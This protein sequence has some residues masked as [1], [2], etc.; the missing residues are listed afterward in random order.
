MTYS[1]VR[2]HRND[3]LMQTVKIYLLALDVHQLVVVGYVLLDAPLPVR[4]VE[5]FGR[6]SR[7]LTLGGLWA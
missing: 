6:E 2:T 1:L 7:E 5:G 3:L 4:S